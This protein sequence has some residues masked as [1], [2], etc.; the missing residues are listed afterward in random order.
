ML[1]I[2]LIM[3]V[4]YMGV[5]Y[6]A[7][8]CETSGV[9]D[10]CN[11]LTVSFITLDN[12]LNKIDSLNLSLKQNDGYTI[13]PEAMDINKI[14]LIK[15]HKHSLDLSQAKDKLL[16]FLRKNKG[17]YNLIP[18]GHNI[19]FDIKFIKSSGLLTEFEYSKFISYNSIDTVCVA[20]F[21]K[22]SGFLNEK[23]SLS[24]VNLCTFAKLQR[25]PTLEHSSDYDTHMTIELLK[26]FKSIISQAS[27]ISSPNLPNKKRKIM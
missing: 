4:K 21:L 19:K 11:L 18:I 12:D 15:H 16:D 3:E 20:Q 23:Q 13:Y 1:T 22:L 2:R 14:D 7:F 9:N 26:Y 5:K 24:L 10:K 6:I 25:K 8:D 17:Q 27:I